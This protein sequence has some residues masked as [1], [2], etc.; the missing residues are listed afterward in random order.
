MNDTQSLPD[1]CASLGITIKVT[2]G[3][4]VQDKEWCHI[5]STCTLEYQGRTMSI[6]FRQ[7]IGHLHKDAQGHTLHALDLRKR[8]AGWKRPTVAD[9]LHSLC[10]DSE[11]ADMTHADWCDAFGYDQDSRKGLETFLQCQ[12]I[13][14]RLRSFLG[15]ALSTVREAAREY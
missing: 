7:G 11:T 6:P 10:L 12:D 3:R 14:V 1:L 2:D 5:A 4:Y 13:G 9:V 8:L 15:S